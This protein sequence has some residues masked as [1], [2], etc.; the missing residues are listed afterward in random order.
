[1]RK[2]GREKR[3]QAGRQANRQEGRKERRRKGRKKAS[4]GGEEEKKC[5]LLPKAVDSTGTM[6]LLQKMYAYFFIYYIF[7]EYIQ[8]KSIKHV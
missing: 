5:V 2:G 8:S 4:K 3:G 7:L 1:M 6:R